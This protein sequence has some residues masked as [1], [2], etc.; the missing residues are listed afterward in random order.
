[1]SAGALP[2]VLVPDAANRAALTAVRSLG[3][4]G[5]RV[6]VGSESR[7]NLASHSRWAAEVVTHSSAAKEPRAFAEEVGRAAVRTGCAVVMPAADVPANALIGHRDALPADVRLLVPPADALALAH[8]KARLAD[9]ARELGLAV[10]EGF[11]GGP[12]VAD[13]PRTAALGYPLV[14]KP[15]V[16]RYLKDGRWTGAAV[17]IVQD[18]DELVRLAGAAP[19]TDVP[20]LVQAKVPG[21]GRG[22]FVLAKEGRVRCAFAHRRIRERPP[23]GGVS[24]LCEA[25]APEPAL[26]ADAERLMAALRWSGVAMVEYKWDPDTQRHWLMEINGRFWGSMQLAVAAGVDFP[27]LLYEQEILGRSET[28]PAARLD[29]RLWWL[30]GDLDHFL[31]RVRRGG[32]GSLG[33]ALRDVLHTREGRRLDTDTLDWHDPRPFLFECAEW[34]RE[35]LR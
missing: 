7:R 10:P 5:C 8:D 27:W 1:M 28:Q 11:V 26:V 35:V 32:L 21:E 14:L 17:K 24:T 31:L 33:A 6:V 34:V 19:F 3:R 22:V 23:W 12:G 20:F 15:A 2:A 16:S 18:R 9:L 25:A 30:P 4:R 29:V 13:D